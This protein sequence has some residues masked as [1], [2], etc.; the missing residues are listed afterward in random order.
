M[1]SVG[2]EKGYRQREVTGKKDCNSCLWPGEHTAEQTG[3]KLTQN[4]PLFCKQSEMQK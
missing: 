3:I 1:P 2:S 4:V